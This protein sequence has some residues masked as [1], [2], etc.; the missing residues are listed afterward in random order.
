[1]FGY[2]RNEI[3]EDYSTSE[4]LVHILINKVARVACWVTREPLRQ[5]PKVES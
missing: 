4:E 3:L 5:L 1:M 2:N